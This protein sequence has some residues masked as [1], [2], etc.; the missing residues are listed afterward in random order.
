MSF[1]LE[2]LNEFVEQAQYVPLSEPA[3][4]EARERFDNRTTG[5]NPE[6]ALG[7]SDGS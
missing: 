1:Y 2:N 5:S 6:E 4:Q 7:A 3:M